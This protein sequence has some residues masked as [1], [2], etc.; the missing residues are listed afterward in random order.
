MKY[1]F[2]P[3]HIATLVFFRIAFGILAFADV[4]G[5][6]TYKHLYKKSFEAEHFHFKYYGF[7]WV[8]PL[9]EP[10]MSLLFIVAMVAAICI[11]IG[12]WY[13]PACVVFALGFSWFFFMEKVFYLNHGYLF[14]LVSIL[15]FFLPARTF[16]IVSSSI[17]HQLSK[18]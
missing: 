13:R 18:I 2:Q 16:E 17:F 7:Q 1:L 12:K 3:T 4:L 11:A 10:F 14:M 5:T 9:P 15:M 8:H 6:W